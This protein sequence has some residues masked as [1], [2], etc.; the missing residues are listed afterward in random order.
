MTATIISSQ[1]YLD[2]AIVAAKLANRDVTVTLSPVFEVDGEQ[3]QVVIDGHHRLEA[4]RKLGVEPIYRE[5]TAQDCDRIL[6]LERGEVEAFLTDMW[7]DDDYYDV[8]TGSIV[9]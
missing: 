1:R 2:E 5:A 7:L 9:W 4:A 3:Y 8:Q 6:L